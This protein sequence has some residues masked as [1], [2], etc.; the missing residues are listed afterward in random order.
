M[1]SEK[2]VMKASYKT[3]EKGPKIYFGNAEGEDSKK[4]KIQVI[5]RTFQVP[6]SQEDFI[7]YIGGEKNF[8]AAMQM[9]AEDYSGTEAKKHLIG[10]DLTQAETR[11]S[12]LK[13]IL[14]SS[15]SFTLASLLEEQTSIKEKASATDEI[16]ALDVSDP[17][18][19]QKV[20]AILA[21]V[22]S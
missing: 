4:N 17:E 3:E 14:R 19:V 20:Q 22:R 18:Y 12:V 16:A 6:E 5:E 1:R 10:V 7:T 2:S 21:K 9:I 11:E 15:E 13:K 8:R